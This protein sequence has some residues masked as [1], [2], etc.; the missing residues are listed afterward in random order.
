V[1]VARES[2]DVPSKIEGIIA[3][4]KVGIGDRVN[5]GD[6][7]A[8]IDDRPIREELA[9]AQATA[10]AASAES[11]RAGA[12][13]AEARQRY[14]RRKAGEGDVISVE[15]AE[16]A[17]YAAQQAGASRSA[18]GASAAEQRTRV[19]QLERMLEETTIVA[20]FAGTIS[21][22]YVDSG[23]LVPRGS[24]VVRLIASDEL[25]V[26]FAV[27]AEEAKKY[28][29][30]DE[31]KVQLDSVSSEVTGVVRRIAPDL[32]PVSQMVTAE[33][34]LRIASAQTGVQAGLAAWV[35]PKKNRASAPGE[36]K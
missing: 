34:E 30:G 36:L 1:V 26:R 6:P 20:P 35:S 13:L 18:A 27:P 7:I 31:I 24:P 19:Q 15:E 28:E 2:T 17:K 21:V 12:V 5:A 9:M 33:A 22:R 16:S 11:R 23:V 3:E 14:K 32:D 29:V 8:V 4:V 10:R 25:W